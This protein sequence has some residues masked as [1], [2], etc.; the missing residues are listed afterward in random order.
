MIV[1]GGAHAIEVNTI[2][3]YINILVQDMVPLLSNAF[4]PCSF[5]IL[6]VMHLYAN[7]YSSRTYIQKF[8]RMWWVSV[9]RIVSTQDLGLAKTNSQNGKHDNKLLGASN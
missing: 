9:P 3:N 8:L 6:Y 4:K 5:Y 1:E 2:N 7:V